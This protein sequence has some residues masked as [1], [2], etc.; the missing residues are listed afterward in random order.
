MNFTAPYYLV[1]IHLSNPDR[2][3]TVRAHN[4]LRQ[5]INDRDYSGCCEPLCVWDPEFD[6]IVYW[7]PSKYSAQLV[8]RML[9]GFLDK[10]RYNRPIFEPLVEDK[11]MG[12]DFGKKGISVKVTLNRFDQQVSAYDQAVLNVQRMILT[13]VGYTQVSQTIL[14]LAQEAVDRL[15]PGQMIA[16]IELTPDR[17]NLQVN[18]R[19]VPASIIIAGL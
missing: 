9:Q 6:S 1:L 7:S 18:V 11:V 8:L 4:Y 2:Y 13:A 10:N 17:R 14:S 3:L 12:V 19:D 5:A 15:Q 16:S